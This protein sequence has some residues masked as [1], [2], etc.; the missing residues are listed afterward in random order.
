VN[1]QMR[2]LALVTAV[3]AVVMIVDVMRDLRSRR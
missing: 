2:V 3:L 1:T